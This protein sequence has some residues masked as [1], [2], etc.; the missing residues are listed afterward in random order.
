MASAGQ[1]LLG[2]GDATFT[3][4]DQDANSALTELDKGLRSGR[5]GEQ[6][7]TIVR[8]P[9]L[10]EKYPFPILINSAC[11]KLAEVFRVGSNF[12]RMLVLKVVQQSERHLDKVLNIDEFVRRIFSVMYSNDPVARALTLRT[13]GS[14]AAIVAERKDLHHSIRSSLESHDAVEQE[15]AI[16]AAARF[17]AQSKA[18]AA[19]MCARIGQ[20]IQ[21]LATPVDTKLRLLGVLEGLHQDAPTAALV[22]DECLHR[23]LPRYPSQSLVQATLRVL[24]RLAAA[25]VTHIPSQIG[26]LVEYLRDDPREGVK[27]QALD[28]LCL[29]ATEQPHLWDTDSV[30]AVVQYAL[31]TPYLNLKC[32]A[33]SVLVLLAQS[34]AVDKFDLMPEDLL[35]LMPEVSSAIE[36]LLM[37]LCT[38]ESDSDDASHALRPTAKAGPTTS[39]RGKYTT[40]TMAKKAAIIQQVQSGRPQVEVAREFNVSK[41]TVMIADAWKAV[42]A[43]TISNSFRHAG[44]TFRDESGTAIEEPDL[45]PSATSFDADIIDDLRSCGMPIPD[46]V[47]FED[48]ANVDSAVSSCAEL[49]D[50]EIIDQGCL[51]CIVLLCDADPDLCSQF[52]DVL[53]SF[54]SFWSG[55]AMLSVCEGLCALGSR[56]CGVLSRIEPRIRQ[57]LSTASRGAMPAIPPKALVL[58][59]TLVLQAGVERGSVPISLDEGLAGMDAWSVYRIARQ[60]TRYGHFAAAAPL[61]ATLANKVS[62]EQLH[63]WLVSLA[64]LCRAEESL[65]VRTGQTQLTDALTHYVRAISALKAATTPAHALQF[66]AEYVRLRCE[67]V[68]AHAQLLQACGCLRTA[69]PPAIAASVASATRDELQKC[70]RVVAQCSRDF[71]SLA[72]QYG[73]LYQT[74]FDADPGTLRN[75]QLLQ[76]NALL[77]MQAIDRIS[78]Y[79]QGINSSEEGGSLVWMEQQPSSGSSSLSEHRLLE[80]AHRGLLWL[81]DLRHQNT[82]TPQQVQLVERLSQELVLVAPCLPRYFFQALQATTIKL[83]VSPQ[84]KGTGEPLFL[85][86]QAQLALRVEGVVQHRSP[87][88]SPARTVHKVLVSLTTTPPSRNQNATT[89][90]KVSSGGDTVQLS[91]VV[92][93]HNDYFQAQFLVALTGQ[94]LHTVT[95]DTSVLD[96]QHTLWKTGPQASASLLLPWHSSLIVFSSQECSSAQVSLTVKC[97]DEAKPSTSMAGPSG[98]APALKPPA[99]PPPPQPFPAPARV[100]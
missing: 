28:D 14:I 89:D 63:F 52:V 78:Q 11:L 9:R 79:N 77:V 36:T 85:A 94:G 71:K 84:Q 68:R 23:L 7:E 76:Q 83:A 16:F 96:A 60:A 29:L 61:F 51:R 20:M 40:L 100:P 15:A 87:P 35:D 55:A 37:I 38:Q 25:T 59:W 57:L 2:F 41:Q 12:L 70:G 13:L 56:R 27:A 72:D 21:G 99:P 33:L 47:N 90:T 98:M 69:P 95:I 82:L 53:G 86:Q 80:A 91:E 48:F 75:V 93:P 92:Q 73:V 22:R 43:D 26:T 45:L 19:N 39:K 67:G 34:V 46:T 1:R 24:T 3:E 5:L 32:G 88:G 4:T 18:F 66:Q 44:F 30:H 65:L 62:S 17:A 54:L 64:E 81:R 8:F 31:S 97:H 49:N 10:F 58:L 50:D 6:C 74:L 42:S